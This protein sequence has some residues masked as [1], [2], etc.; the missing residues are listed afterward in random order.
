MDNRE[1]M[2][3]AKRAVKKLEWKIDVEGQTA[4]K[5]HPAFVCLVAWTNNEG[6]WGWMLAE[7][8]GPPGSDSVTQIVPIASDTRFPTMNAALVDC[9]HA[10]TKVTAKMIKDHSDR[11]GVI[12]DR[13]SSPEADVPAGD[14]LRAGS[15]D[16]G[17]PSREQDGMQQHDLPEGDTLGVSPAEGQ[18]E[19]NPP[20]DTEEI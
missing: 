7:K 11:E 5:V 4:R 15:G 13:E 18:P 16:A 6:Q 12:Y 2:R 9:D 10:L 14:E 17:H 19:G 1:A 3:L 8:Y 20:S